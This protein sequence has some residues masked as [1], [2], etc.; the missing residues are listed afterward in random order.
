MLMPRDKELLKFIE[1]YRAIT[2]QQA[3]DIF[4]EGLEKSAIRRLN[5]LEDEKILSSYMSSKNKVYQY[6]ECGQVSKH[7]LG[8][9]DFYAWIIRNSGEVIEF[10]KEP[11]FFKGMLR[12]DA[13][14]KFKIPYQGSKY[15]INA[16]LE[17]DLNHYTENTKLNTWYEK[18]GREQLVGEFLLIIARPTN[19]IRYNPTNFSIVYTDLKYNNLLELIM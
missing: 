9:L 3:K 1:K 19:S 11:R 5:Q 12:P 2:T 7:D 6:N 14:I 4:F 10:Q 15:S 8:I 18:L 16:I 13:T 17:Y